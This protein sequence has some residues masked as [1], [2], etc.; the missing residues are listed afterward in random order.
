M[1][2]SNHG[3]SKAD[4][5]VVSPKSESPKAELSQS[6]FLKNTWYAAGWSED[7]TDAPYG[8]TICNEKIVIL[9]K[10]DGALSALSGVCPHR[11]ASLVAAQRLDGDRLQCP[12]HGLEFGADGRCVGNPHG[13][14]PNVVRLATYPVVERHSLV[15]LWYGDA[16]AAD[17]ALVPDFSCL[18]DPRCRTIRWRLITNANFELVTDNLMD[19]THVA[20]LH[21]G[22]IGGEGMS[23]GPLKVIQ[24]GTTVHSNRLC[25]DAPPPVWSALFGGYQDNVDLWMDMRWDAPGAMLLDV[26]VTPAGQPRGNGVSAPTAHIL[27]PETETTTHYFWAAARDFDIDNQGNVDTMMRSAVEHAFLNEDKPMLEDVQRNM[28]TK[29]FEEMKP[30]I[31]PFDGGAVQARRML[32]DLRLGRR[33]QLPS[34]AITD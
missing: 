19:L 33:K 28:G 22:G 17:P 11:F 1:S 5:S 6:M 16:E 12:Y 3:S 25:P 15:W 4:R 32:S 30:L 34:S 23:G 31:M 24:A 9:R 18:T 13:A 7:I 29:S 21:R 14:I 2:I 8:I 27:I 10:E 26:G 20:Y